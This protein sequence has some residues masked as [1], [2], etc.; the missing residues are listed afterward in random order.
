M[1]NFDDSQLNLIRHY[2]FTFFNLIGQDNFTIQP[3]PNT[4]IQDSVNFSFTYTVTNSILNTA[5]FVFYNLSKETISLFS[6]TQNRRG[7][8]FDT[9]YANKTTGN[10][11]LFSGLTYTVNTYRQGTDTIT[12]VVGC[13]LFLN[14]L[15]KGITASY[16]AGT[17]YLSIVQNLLQK[18][19]SIVTLS[20]LS[21]QFLSSK[22]YKS[23]KTFKGQL[24]TILKS[25]A[26]DAGLIFSIQLNTITMIPKNL[27]TYTSNIVQTINKYNG[28]VGTVRAEALST[29]LFPVTYFENQ[30][31]NQNLSILTVN[32]LI[33]AYSLYDK[34]KLES[35]QF[36]GYY[37]ILGLTYNGEWRS[38]NWYATLRLWPDKNRS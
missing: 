1:Q 8:V 27:N 5:H 29:Q 32:T 2:K 15:F 23:P 33:R 26:A 10:T 18:Y 4:V 37:G 35:E 9:W 16:P 6:S 34:I 20:S 22:T 11:T 21:N 17:T 12:E 30:N 7:F 31:I 36:N 13:D 19:G 24:M 14:L 25:I 38:N 3:I 28:L